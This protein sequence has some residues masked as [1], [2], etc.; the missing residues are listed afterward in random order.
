MYCLCVNVYCHR[1]TTQLQLINISYHSRLHACGSYVYQGR[2]NVM[3]DSFPCAFGILSVIDALMHLH[4]VNPPSPRPKKQ[5][6]SRSL[7]WEP[8]LSHVQSRMNTDTQ[9]YLIL[10]I[11]EFRPV[12]SEMIIIVGTVPLQHN[13]RKLGN[14]WHAE[15]TMKLGEWSGKTQHLANRKTDDWKSSCWLTKELTSQLTYS[16]KRPCWESGISS[17]S[18]EISPD[19]RKPK[20]IIMFRRS[21]HLSL[22]WGR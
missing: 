12:P 19:W 16:M 3:T 4:G 22:S 13:T 14:A 17:T 5:L 20:C 8:R 15:S 2:P 11:I 6:S 21:C 10:R 1:V 18:Q 7:P 9:L